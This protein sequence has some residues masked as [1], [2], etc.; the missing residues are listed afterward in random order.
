MPD[1]GS[2]DAVIAFDLDT[3]KRRW[4][5][6][7]RAGDFHRL[8]SA[9][10]HQEDRNDD[11]SGS[12][13]LYTLPNG[14]Q[15]LIA[16]QESGRITALDPDRN[17][18][19][20][21]VAQAADVMRPEGQGFG[22]AADGELYYRPLAVCS[23]A[24][25]REPILNCDSD[26]TGA[27]VAFRPATGERVWSTTHPKPTNCSDPEATWCSSGLFGAA[28]VIPG[29]V[30]AG[31]KDGTLR[32][33]STADGE[34]LWEYNTMQEYETVNGV[35]AQGGSIGGHGPAIVGGMLFMGSGYVITSAPGNV[36]LAF[37][38]E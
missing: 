37:G 30:F 14:R 31:A 21:W 3:G 16:G 34:V 15:I 10:T 17:G 1:S 12:P 29:A 28:T 20:L 9:V 6:Q 4:S 2:S 19:V 33:Y 35:R 36:L 25:W 32:A 18:A 26:E 38:V 11:V 5:T 24:P 23:S 13:V 8:D 22:A 27:L 7:L